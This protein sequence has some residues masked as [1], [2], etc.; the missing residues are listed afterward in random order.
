M[1]E[2]DDYGLMRHSL[3]KELAVA[4]RATLS[5]PE[6]AMS[7]GDHWRTSHDSDDSVL[8]PAKHGHLHS[9]LSFMGM[10]LDVPCRDK[11]L[12]RRSFPN[13]PALHII[14]TRVA[15]E[16]VNIVHQRDLTIETLLR[17][18]FDKGWLFRPFMCASY[19]SIEDIYLVCLVLVE[20]SFINT[21]TGIM[22]D[23]GLGQN[24]DFRLKEDRKSLGKSYMAMTFSTFQRNLNKPF[25]KMVESAI[26]S[27]VPTNDD[28]F[29]CDDLDLC[30]LINLGRI[31]IFWTTDA[32]EHLQLNMYS[33]GYGYLKVYWFKSS[34]GA[35][36]YYPTRYELGLLCERTLAIDCLVSMM[37]PGVWKKNWRILSTS[38][39]EVAERVSRK[40]KR[41]GEHMSRYKRHVG[42]LHST[43]ISRPTRS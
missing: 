7:F 10:K 9:I 24:P 38:Y 11:E 36:R 6:H 32:L 13:G 35:D 30:S 25:Q 41:C 5:P 12:R 16:A 14:I 15:I 34:P 27:E 26:R 18:C 37:F 31:K 2:D 1:G 23:L 8:S 17:R 39:L 22:D 19:P 4:I 40:K 3:A 42:Y 20:V 21:S 43:R 29:R 28:M 33:S